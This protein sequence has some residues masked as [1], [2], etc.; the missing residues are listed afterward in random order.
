MYSP[1]HINLPDI[2]RIARCECTQIPPALPCRATD[3]CIHNNEASLDVFPP[4]LCCATGECIPYSEASLVVSPALSCFTTDKYIHYSEPSLEVSSAVL[5][6]WWMH[7]EVLPALSCRSTD[8]SIHMSI[9]F[10]T[11]AAQSHLEL[12]SSTDCIILCCN[13]R[14]YSLEMSNKKA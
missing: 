2:L 9:T 13:R 7:L 10:G 8:K 1:R 11:D 3:G 4:S 6:D 12:R 5:C 14:T